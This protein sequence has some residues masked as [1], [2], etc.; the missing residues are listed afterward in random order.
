M[1]GIP[2]EQR[3]IMAIEAW[4]ASKHMESAIKHLEDSKKQVAD[5]GKAAAKSLDNEPEE[6]SHA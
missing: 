2:K 5:V 3:R 4:A 6:L 1:T